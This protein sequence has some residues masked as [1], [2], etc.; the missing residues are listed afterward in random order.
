MTTEE[1]A[2]DHDHEHGE[3]DPNSSAA[4]EA[5]TRALQSLLVERELISTD[6]IASIVSVYDED[7]GPQNGAEVVARAWADESFKQRLLDDADAAIDEF[8]FD[9]GHRHIQVVENTP[10]VHNIVV[11]TLCSCYPWSLLGLPP[12][13]YKSPEYRARVPREPRSVLAEFGVDIDDSVDVNVWDANSE[14]RF[15]VLPQQ[16]PGTEGLPEAELVEHVTRDAM[17]GTERLV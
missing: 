15:L 5:R 10:E 3:P 17:V 6:A 7:V 11:C 12:T 8:D 14:L 1:H 2:H 13:W 4:L 9:V 16:P